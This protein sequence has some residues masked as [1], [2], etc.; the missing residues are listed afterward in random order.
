[1]F[2]Y[3]EQHRTS[4]TLHEHMYEFV[5]SLTKVRNIFKIIR[6][7]CNMSMKIV[8]KSNNINKCMYEFAKPQ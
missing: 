5:E 8:V 2:L 4:S 6:M 3:Q 7:I 1:M